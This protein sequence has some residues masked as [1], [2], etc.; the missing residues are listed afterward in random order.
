MA[1]QFASN[2]TKIITLYSRAGFVIQTILMDMEFNKVAPE[3]PDVIIN[4][5]TAPEHVAE[6]ERSIRVVKERFRVCMSVMPFKRLPNIMTINL[7]HF[8]VFW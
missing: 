7:V 5:S 1:K 3:L 8:C 4:T 6:V 2:L